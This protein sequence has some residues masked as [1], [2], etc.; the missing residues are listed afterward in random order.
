MGDWEPVFTWMSH[1]AFGAVLALVGLVGI[2]LLTSEAGS[3]NGSSIRS[4]D[5]C[6]SGSFFDNQDMAQCIA[7][8]K[9]CQ[10]NARYETCESA[11]GDQACTIA[12]ARSSSICQLFAPLVVA[13]VGALALGV[14]IIANVYRLRTHNMLGMLNTPAS[15][16]P[17]IMLFDGLSFLVSISGSGVAWLAN[18]L[19]LMISSGLLAAVAVYSELCRS[20]TRRSSRAIHLLLL[21]AGIQAI[22]MGLYTSA[23]YEWTHEGCVNATSAGLASTPQPAIFS[24]PSSC[25]K[26]CFGLSTSTLSHQYDADTQDLA[27]RASASYD[28]I[29]GRRLQG[30]VAPPPPP[31]PPPPQNATLQESSWSGE[32]DTEETDTETDTEETDSSGDTIDSAVCAAL[33]ADEG[34]C[35]QDHQVGSNQLISCAQACHIREQGTDQ[36]RCRELCDERAEA[37]GCSTTVNGITYGHCESCDDRHEACPHGVQDVSSCHRGCELAGGSACRQSY[38][39]DVESSQCTEYWVVDA[40]SIESCASQCLSEPTCAFIQ[41][42][43]GFHRRCELVRNCD[44]ISVP[45]SGGIWAIHSRE[46]LGNLTGTMNASDTVLVEDAAGRVSWDA[47]ELTTRFAVGVVFGRQRCMC[48][49]DEPEETVDQDRCLHAQLEAGPTTIRLVPKVPGS[50]SAGRI[51]GTYVAMG[52]LN[53]RRR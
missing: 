43:V 44:L 5:F 45:F 11:R 35:C 32:P 46:C 53:G 7:H 23:T 1:S 40:D 17:S 6:L 14:A 29:R 28:D 26:R 51:A 27:A 4:N 13:A 3:C 41:S 22:T 25:A 33:C 39:A 10:W 52:R 34:H 49:I 48:G 31:P 30:D 21:V 19:N 42:D 47:S 18:D 2:L 12:G 37:R 24:S 36:A 8:S 38:T 20:H 50:L 15:L 16:W 9:C